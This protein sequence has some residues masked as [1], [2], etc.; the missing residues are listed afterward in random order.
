MRD[1]ITPVGTDRL[2]PIQVRTY[3]TQ[4]DGISYEIRS[5]DI[6]RLIAD[7]TIEDYEQTKE[8]ISASLP[9]QNLLEENREYLLIIKLSS[10]ENTISYY[11]R[12]IEEQ[13]CYVD[14]CVSFAMDFHEKTF[15]EVQSKDLAAYLEPNASGDNST[16]NKVDIH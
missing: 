11:T 4:V 14:E 6:D 3:D 8:K 1:T 9:I 10:G 16:F 12:I 7:A 13:N 15:D 5:M 2:L